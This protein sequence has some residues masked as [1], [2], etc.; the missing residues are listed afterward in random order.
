[1][2]GIYYASTMPPTDVFPSVDAMIPFFQH[3]A[4]SPTMVR[5]SFEV[6]KAAVQGNNPGQTPV[7]CVDQPFFAKGK[8]L[9][10]S[11]DSEYGEDKFVLLP[12]GL[13]TEMTSYKMLGH[14]LEGCG[15][16][17]A[18]Q[19]AK[20]ASSGVHGVHVLKW[21]YWCLLLFGSCIEWTLACMLSH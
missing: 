18:L 21:K 5:H 6:V 7:I 14:W 3:E 8:H 2:G 10:W 1:M 17:E 12:G 9:Q 20:L 13:H 16:I 19:E 11:L 4:S 15:R